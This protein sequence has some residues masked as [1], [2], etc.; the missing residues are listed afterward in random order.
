MLHDIT[1]QSNIFIILVNIH[2]KKTSKESVLLETAALIC[3]MCYNAKSH[4]IYSGGGNN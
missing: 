3:K 2:K 4:Q 1:D